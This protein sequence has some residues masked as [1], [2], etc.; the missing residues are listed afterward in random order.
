MA[1]GWGRWEEMPPTF[2]TN[3]HSGPYSAEGGPTKSPPSALAGGA[4]GICS[5]CA[6][7]GICPPAAATSLGGGD[8]SL[9][10]TAPAAPRLFPCV[11]L[12]ERAPNGHTKKQPGTVVPSCKVLSGKRDSDPRPQP[13]QG[14]ALPTELFPRWDCKDRQKISFSKIINKNRS[15]QPPWISRFFSHT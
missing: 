1:A 12:C 9:A 4:C 3:P 8:Q 7:G 15:F 10:A 14:C 6:A 2:L 5:A 13:W 11:S